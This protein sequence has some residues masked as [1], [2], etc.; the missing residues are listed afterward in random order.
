M[1]AAG[2]LGLFAFFG[3]AA[4]AEQSSERF[5]EEPASIA[6]EPAEDY[7]D[8]AQ[9]PNAPSSDGALHTIPAEARDRRGRLSAQQS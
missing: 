7:R 1:A 8:E 5:E 9:W 6:A 2:C 3:C 4:P